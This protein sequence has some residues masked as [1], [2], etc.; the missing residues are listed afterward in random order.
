MSSPYDRPNVLKFFA[1][2]SGKTTKI[3]K[4]FKKCT[5]QFTQFLQKQINRELILQG[6]RKIVTI[7]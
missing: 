5:S 1:Q 4:F 3:I 7:K 6:I 2:C